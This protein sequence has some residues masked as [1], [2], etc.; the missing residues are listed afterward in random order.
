[1]FEGLGRSIYQAGDHIFK[2]NDE[3][4]CA[5]LIESGSVEV[6]ALWGKSFHRIAIL[7]K[8]DLFGEMA[9]IDNKPRTATIT[10]LEETRVIEIS[11]ELID[12]KLAKEDPIIQHLLLLVL[13]RFRN[14]QYQNTWKDRIS[15]IDESEDKDEVFSETQKDLIKHIRVASDIN[16]A[17]KREE[18]QIYYQPIIS[19]DESCL[20]GFEALIRWQ[21]P[22]NGMI[23]PAQFLN[24]AEETDQIIEIGKWVLNRVCIDFDVLS[25]EF[26]SPAGQPPLFISVNLSARQLSNAEQVAELTSII[27]EHGIDP[28]CIKLEV[29]ETV[30]IEDPDKA[31]EL[32]SALRN[33]GFQIALDDFGTGFS[34]LSYLQKFAFDT[35]KIDQSF[36]KD[37]LTNSSSM[38]IVNA[39]IGLADALELNVIAEGVEYEKELVELNKMKCAYAQ[40]YYIAKP[41]PLPKA[42]EFVKQEKQAKKEV[43]NS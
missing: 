34:S 43:I 7:G 10:A 13:K 6:S 26:H 4:H 20:A 15:Q 32:L 33:L 39:S 5:Y 23:S 38:Q 12:S 28:A 36:T 40:G 21:H 31:Q 11:K 14:T 19:I 41:M 29:T 18:F 1:M 35:L 24:I 37:M 2:E 16:E 17:L 25:K 8:D 30:L 42:I 3:G 22:V 27:N 9:L